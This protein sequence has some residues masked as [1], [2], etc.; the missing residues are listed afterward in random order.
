MAS[1][2]EPEMT[3]RIRTGFKP[4]PAPMVIYKNHINFKGM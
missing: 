1:V 2:L 3:K 4:V